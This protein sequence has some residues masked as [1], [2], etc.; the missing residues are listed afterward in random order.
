MFDLALKPLLKISRLIFCLACLLSSNAITQTTFNQRFNYGTLTRASNIWELA[1]GF[2]ISGVYVD[3]IDVHNFGLFIRKVDFDGSVVFNKFYSKDGWMIYD[4][5]DTGCSTSDAYVLATNTMVDGNSYCQLWWFNQEWDTI[6]TKLY[7]SPFFDPEGPAS[8]QIMTPVSVTIDEED[9]IYF[10]C[11][12]FSG[13][14]NEF[15][16]TKVNENGEVLWQ[17]MTNTM[18][19]E[20]YCLALFP[21][22]NGVVVSYGQQ[23][24]ASFSDHYFKL[25]TSPEGNWQIEWEV[26][27]VNPGYSYIQEFDFHDNNVTAASS[28]YEDTW[29][30][31]K[32]AAY[33]INMNGDV[34]WNAIPETFIYSQYR[35]EQLVR[36]ADGSFIGVAVER[37]DTIEPTVEE[38][39]YNT[40][41]LL[42]KLAANGEILWT[43]RIRNVVSTKDQHKI[44]DLKICANGSIV[45]C[46]EANDLAIDIEGEYIDSVPTQGWFVKTDSYGCLEPDCQSNQINDNLPKIRGFEVY[47]NP[48]S[49]ELTIFMEDRF[50]IDQDYFFLYDSQGNFVESFQPTHGSEV[51]V[52]PTTSLRTGLYVLAR[53][54]GDATWEYRKI[55]KN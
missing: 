6:Q 53:F 45:F 31:L 7:T 27:P 30:G 21:A 52:L 22:S 37:D 11:I 5:E 9:N 55:I 10:S 14:S 8:T 18:N 1:D 2:A 24:G 26:N 33:Q 35:L 4:Y 12:A 13:T 47:P 20:E 36:N 32:P 17:Y 28:Y 44:A 42:V 39:T 15:D 43:Q 54:D 51:F 16:I 38:G 46:G 34:Q 23:S 50:R 3:T 40:Q 48:F 49:D 19:I 25:N 41:A 29:L